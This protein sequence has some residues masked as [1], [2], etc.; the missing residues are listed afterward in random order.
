MWYCIFLS[1]LQIAVYKYFIV[2][3][4]RGSW[5]SPWGGER[6]ASIIIIIDSSSRIVFVIIIIINIFSSLMSSFDRIP[7]LYSVDPWLL[8]LFIPHDVFWSFWRVS[9]EP[10]CWW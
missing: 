6:Y 3:L 4:L 5:A 10:E 1:V 8:S 9:G 2:S 7:I